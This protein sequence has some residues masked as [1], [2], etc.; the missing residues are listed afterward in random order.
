VP[1]STSTQRTLVA[2]RLPKSHAH[3]ASQ[4]PRRL[5][6]ETNLALANPLASSPSSTCRNNTESYISSRNHQKHQKDF[7]LY[8]STLPPRRGFV[9]HRRTHMRTCSLHRCACVC[10]C[11]LHRCASVRTCLLQRRAPKRTCSPYSHA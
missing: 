3:L 1:V 2:H 7:F 5:A 10:T 11:S 4:W 9:T 6:V 8:T